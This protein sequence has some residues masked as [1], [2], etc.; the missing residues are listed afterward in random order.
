MT[1]S[2]AG[3][4]FRR[5]TE[6]DHAPIVRLVDEWWGGR[7]VSGLLQRVWFQHFTGTSWIAEDEDG[8]LLGFLV[9][10]ISPDDPEVGYVK[11]IG[12][13]PNRR[14]HGL[15]AELY[16]RFFDDVAGRGV[17]RVKAI[18]WPG[19]RASVG[20]HQSIGFGLVD[21]PG[22][23]NLFGFPAFADYDGDGED[24]IVFVRELD[25]EA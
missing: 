8:H 1:G 20:F 3:V 10:F 13:N 15:G 2:D 24:R 17:R 16:R 6:S 22:T 11:M 4:R 5:P 9:G 23:Q 14:R 18:T 21:G 12:T 7:R 25:S 19:N